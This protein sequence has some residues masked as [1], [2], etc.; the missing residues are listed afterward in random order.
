MSLTVE[1]TIS[2]EQLMQAVGRHKL[3]G[4]FVFALVFAAFVSAWLFLPREYGSEGRMV[5]R[6]GRSNLSINATPEAASMVSIQD[7]RETEILSVM[8]LIQSHAV[9]AQVVDAIGPEK[10][11]ANEMEIPLSFFNRESEKPVD[12]TAI[13]YAVAR[14]RE[15]AIKRLSGELVV[16]S[17]KRS[18]NISVFCTGAS[19]E[20]AQE[21]VDELMSTTQD[22]HVQV[23]SVDRSRSMF[24]R[25]LEQKESELKMAQQ[26]LEKF[27]SE[28]G[29]L[30][31]DEARQTLNGVI[32]K[33]ENDLVNTRV[34][35][36][37]SIAMV[38]E[39]E[40]QASSIDAEFDL[41]RMGMEKAATAGAQGTLYERI[42]EK[43]RLMARYKEGHPK[44]NEIN[45][46]ISRLRKDVGELEEDRMEFAKIRNPVYEQLQVALIKETA[47][48]E[49][50]QG[51]L[52]QIEIALGDKAHHLSNL[53]RLKTE[54]SFLERKI[55]LAQTTF[56]SYA[57]K[58]NEARMVDQLEKE[59]ISDV[60]IQQPAT[61][62]FRKVSPKGSV[63]LSAG[64]L[65]AIACGL[66]ATLF[67]DRKQLLQTASP[68]EIA[69]S[70]DV[71]ILAAL[72]RTT[73]S[74]TVSTP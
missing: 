5:V 54:A 71:P 52:Q 62:M 45:D 44:I 64:L 51:R 72:P 10:I 18:P 74:R 6:V 63:I 14:K 58:R 33:L 4:V 66:L 57:K 50:L 8:D 53:N 34:N 24:D 15:K 13:Q 61:L 73:V 21:I 3:L 47:N 38:A 22:V 65:F 43:A 19:P 35:L 68:E 23:H 42:A 56:D 26:E 29:F 48:A 17:E 9:L 25:E 7:T 37:Q 28:N 1:K 70:L 2:I 69:E 12:P 32:D 27:A 60:V 59:D 67:A 55:G 16:A 36:K 30:S 20:L 40:K 41:P 46:E 49:A 11:L 31:I 39:F